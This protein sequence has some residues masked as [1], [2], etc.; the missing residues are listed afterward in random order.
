MN[1]P[2]LR[3]TLAAQIESF[4]KTRPVTKCP[5]ALNGFKAKAKPTKPTPNHQAENYRRFVTEIKG[6]E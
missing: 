5:P 6:V 2:N 3:E 4:M 1:Q